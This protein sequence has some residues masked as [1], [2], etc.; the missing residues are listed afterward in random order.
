[1]ALSARLFAAAALLCLCS[2]VAARTL[3]QV[4]PG[5]GRNC[6]ASS[7]CRRVAARRRPCG[8]LPPRLLHPTPQPR[9]HRFICALTPLPQD[10]NAKIW[11]N[12][13]L[14]RATFYASVQMKLPAPETDTAEK[15]AE[16]CLADERCIFWSWCPASVA[17]GCP[18]AGAN[19]TTQST[20]KPKTC[21]LSWDTATDS[22]AV[23]AMVRGTRAREARA[24][25][26]LRSCQR[27][28]C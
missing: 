15:C 28:S 10:E 5:C 21:L 7:G 11:S 23:F 17:A 13:T 6:P 19:G 25:L 27:E 12:Y 26:V 22:L 1:M 3:K 24:V 2:T 16:A 4:R 20:P 9:A 18:V 14:E 8:A